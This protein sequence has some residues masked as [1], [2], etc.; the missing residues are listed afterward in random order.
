MSEKLKDHNNEILSLLIN[1]QI[2]K[3]I[4]ANNLK[5]C[6]FSIRQNFDLDQFLWDIATHIYSSI[7]E[8]IDF[9]TTTNKIKKCQEF[10]YVLYAKEQEKQKQEQEKLLRESIQAQ[11]ESISK[12][13]ASLEAKLAQVFNHQMIDQKGILLKIF[14]LK[15]ELQSLLVR[16]KQLILSDMDK[17]M[18][19]FNLELVAVLRYENLYIIE[20]YIETINQ[21]LLRVELEIKSKLDEEE[22]AKLNRENH[23]L[24][25]V[26]QI[27]NSHKHENDLIKI[28]ELIESSL[29]IHY[30]QIKLDSDISGDLGADELDTIELGMEIEELVNIE[31]PNELLGAYRVGGFSDGHSY[32]IACS[33]QELLEYVISQLV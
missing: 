30:A 27:T 21:D 33:I 20:S 3:I 32:P 18:K 13:I 16:E 2:D 26:K 24:S 17:A 8:K 15:K 12:E 1:K 5:D 25:I 14:E 28:L 29:E 10:A 31:I 23:L 11:K 4:E 6:Y 19:D 22:N 7:G 9:A